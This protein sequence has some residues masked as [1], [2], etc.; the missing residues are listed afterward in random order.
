MALEQG[1]EQAPPD[2]AAPDGKTGPESS[3]VLQSVPLP[4]G[5]GESESKTTVLVAF[6]A[7]ILIA[8]AMHPGPASETDRTYGALGTVVAERAIGVDGP[9][10]EYYP[11]G[12]DPAGDYR[13]EICWPVFLT[14]GS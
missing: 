6:A 2:A 4:R 5:G 12:F 8:V 3:D 9:I 1:G 11:D 10:R 7:N 13:T 14:A